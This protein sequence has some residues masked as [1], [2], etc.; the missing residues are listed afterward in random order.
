MRPDTLF[1]IMI[2]RNCLLI[3]PAAIV[4]SIVT[5]NCIY[6]VYGR[7]IYEKRITSLCAVSVAKSVRYD[8]WK[9]IK[10]RKA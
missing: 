7:D 6:V 10:T 5:Q 2:A 4:L 8:I 3:A 9:E 1:G